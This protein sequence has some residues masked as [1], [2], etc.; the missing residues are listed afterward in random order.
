MLLLLMEE[1]NVYWKRRCDLW[2]VIN[3]Q[4]LCLFGNIF[5]LL[6]VFCRIV[7][8]ATRGPG[9]LQKSERYVNQHSGNESL[10]CTNLLQEILTKYHKRSV[11]DSLEFSDLICAV[12]CSVARQNTN[13]MYLFFEIVQ[14]KPRRLNPANFEARDKIHDC[15]ALE[16]NRLEHIS[17]FIN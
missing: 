6:I 17:S 14:Y 4:P 8:N 2:S 12:N 5:Y 7:C 11:E 1:Y 15:S 9:T 3:V 10:W 16:S 13:P